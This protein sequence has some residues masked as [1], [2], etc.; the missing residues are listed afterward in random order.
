MALQIKTPVLYTEV[1]TAKERKNPTK[2][3]DMLQ[4]EAFGHM[5]T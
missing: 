1:Q 4:Q 2:I 3:I 5:N